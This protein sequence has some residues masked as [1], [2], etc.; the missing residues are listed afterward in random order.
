MKVISKPVSKP[1]VPTTATKVYTANQYP[2]SI[3][4]RFTMTEAFDGKIETVPPIDVLLKGRATVR[5]VVI[6]YRSA[7]CYNGSD[8]ATLSNQWFNTELKTETVQSFRCHANKWCKASED[9]QPLIEKGDSAAAEKRVAT[10]DK[11]GKMTKSL[12]QDWLLESLKDKA[13]A[14]AVA[15]AVIDWIDLEWSVDQ[16]EV[17]IAIEK[18]LDKRDKK[19]LAPKRTRKATVKK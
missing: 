17:E 7:A 16:S 19:T 13:I 18:A 9:A 5:K 8:L 12:F 1:I 6:A 2:V 11:S 4:D 3:G 10:A 15:I 14:K